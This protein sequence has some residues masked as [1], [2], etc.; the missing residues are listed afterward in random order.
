[1]T[2]IP[3]S[4]NR[5][6]AGDV[7]NT[8]TFSFPSPPS[9]LK[10]R[11]IFDSIEI[12]TEVLHLHRQAGIKNAVCCAELYRAI[13]RRTSRR[14]P[15]TF[16]SAETLAEDI[17][18]SSGDPKAISPRTVEHG[19]AAMEAGGWIFREP[20]AFVDGK[21]VRM[22]WAL[23]RLPDDG[24]GMVFDLGHGARVDVGRLGVAALPSLFAP[25]GARN[26][27]CGAT[28]EPQEVAPDLNREKSNTIQITESSIIDI[29]L[30]EVQHAAPVEST[31]LPTPTSTPEIASRPPVEL[32][33]AKLAEL[34]A[35]AIRFPETAAVWIWALSD[36]GREDL[37]PP[38]LRGKS[39]P[40]RPRPDPSPLP[41]PVPV[42]VPTA[43][44]RAAQTPAATLK[45][46]LA[47]FQTQT[48]LERLLGEPPQ[49]REEIVWILAER[50]AKAFDNYHSIA[51]WRS[52]LRMVAAGKITT[53]DWWRAFVDS[54]SA[55][56]G[57]QGS[58]FNN[59]MK[60]LKARV[61]AQQAQ[62]S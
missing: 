54:A 14:K 22:I 49:V 43:P 62:V 29:K 50:Q 13:H 6:Q 24:T 61:R 51:C 56:P 57:Y 48:L 59:R 25:E 5:H 18:E 40:P 34:G 39:K 58:T 44:A 19:L 23:W 53:A 32:A 45:V 15:G 47:S 11:R 46:P 31:P 16:V 55:S 2:I 37:L 36:Q 10:T 41:D 28:L 60:P 27:P 7:E 33:A 26:A 30:P 4:D 42:A 8:P 21:R 9:F 17:C 52:T 1:M 38:R 12:P 3:A 20:E 35:A